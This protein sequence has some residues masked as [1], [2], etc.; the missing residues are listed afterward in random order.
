[1]NRRTCALPIGRTSSVVVSNIGAY[2]YGALRGPSYLLATRIQHRE[3]SYS[4]G[5]LSCLIT[6]LAPWRIIVGG[7]YAAFLYL[8]N[9]CLFST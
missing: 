3:V 2:L 7:V 9:I 5:S 6:G 8:N 1:M 4:L